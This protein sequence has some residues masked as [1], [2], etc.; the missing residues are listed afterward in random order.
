MGGTF[1]YIPIHDICS[2]MPLIKR[3]ALLAFHSFTGCDTTSFFA[4]VGKKTFYD[5]WKGHPELTPTLAFLQSCPDEIPSEYVDS[6]ERFLISS[7]SPTCPYDQLDKARQYIFSR[8]SRGFD[9]LP[10]TRAALVEHI[11]RATLQAGDWSQ[12]LVPLQERA[13]PSDWGWEDAGDVWVP[14]WTSLECASTAM[15]NELI[16]CSCTVRCTGNCSCTKAGL[17]C[18]SL[19]RCGGTCYKPST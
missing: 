9:Y 15:R 3:Q 8:T 6:I 17:R 4:G 7:Y 19:C 2:K 5:N 13:N 10:P 1:R 18:T 14:F 11:K 16:R 12:C